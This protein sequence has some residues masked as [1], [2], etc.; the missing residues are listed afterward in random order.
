MK[1]DRS[2]VRCS[3]RGETGE[4]PEVGVEDSEGRCKKGKKVQVS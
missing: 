1:R 2:R 4:G 3:R